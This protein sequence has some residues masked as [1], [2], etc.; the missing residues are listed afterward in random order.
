M[1]FAPRR[2]HLLMNE[3]KDVVVMDTAEPLKAESDEDSRLVIEEDRRGTEDDEDKD[4][5]SERSLDLSKTGSATENGYATSMTS[6]YAPAL[7]Q[8]GNA[9]VAHNNSPMGK[10]RLALA[11]TTR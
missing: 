5:H 9:N 4:G 10:K 2:G 7:D 6:L 1:D 8:N 11:I 3:Y